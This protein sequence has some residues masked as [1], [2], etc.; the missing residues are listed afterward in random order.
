MLKVEALV[1][2]ERIHEVTKALEASGC[3]GCYY[4]N[5][6]GQG[7]QKS[8]G[9]ITG[10]GGQIATRSAVPETRVTVIIQ[11]DQVE[12]VVNAIVGAART[13]EE[14][15]GSDGKIFVSEIADAIRIRNGDRGDSAL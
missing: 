15:H 5:V 13:S 10:R 14:A 1:R 2:P 6:T 3:T 8:V 4:D 7:S 12:A 11:N 9:V